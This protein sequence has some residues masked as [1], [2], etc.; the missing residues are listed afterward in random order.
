MT[1]PGSGITRSFSM[2]NAPSAEGG[3]PSCSFIIKKYPQGAFS[4]QLD[5]GLEAGDALT[6]KG[7]YGT[8]FRREGRPGPMVL[9]GGGSGMSPLWSILQ[10]HIAQ[11]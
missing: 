2:A 5:G 8:C 7:P 1:I 6:A 3:G 11:R 10:D 4:S 9:V